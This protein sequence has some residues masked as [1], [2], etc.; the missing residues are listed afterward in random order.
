MEALD[1]K[2]T[3]EDLKRLLELLGIEYR[4]GKELRGDTPEDTIRLIWSNSGSASEYWAAL[5][6]KL[7]DV[8][9]HLADDDLNETTRRVLQ[10]RLDIG[11]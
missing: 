4:E 7:E 5:C 2:Y 11:K 8:S 10:W 6:V 3:R 1:L 9:R